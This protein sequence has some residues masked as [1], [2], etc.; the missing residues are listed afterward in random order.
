MF[1]TPM[2]L[3]IGADENPIVVTV[4]RERGII[5]LNYINY[6]ENVF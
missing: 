1:S 2:S 6:E 5:L 4:S 3:L